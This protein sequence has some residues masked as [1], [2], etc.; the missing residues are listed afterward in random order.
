MRARRFCVLFF[1]MA[2]F[3]IAF[4]T[5]ALA[6]NETTA[7][8]DWTTCADC[9]NPGTYA[10][11]GTRFGPHGGY[12]A[13]SSACDACHTVHAAPT[14]FKLLQGATV[15]ATCMTCHDG[16][17]TIG[18]GVYGAIKGR[19]LNVSGQHRV[20]TTSV[21]P[22]GSASTGGSLTMALAGPNGTLTCS[23]CHSPHGSDCVTPYLGERQRSRAW[24]ILTLQTQN[25]LLRRHPGNVSTATAD[26]GSDW[27][28]AC[29]AGRDSGLSTV[30]NHPADSKSTTATPFTYNNVARLSAGANAT[31]TTLG[32][33]G[34]NNGG[35]LMPYPRTTQQKGHAP[36]C[37]QCHEDARN[38]GTL[39]S[40]GASGT[41]SPYVVT[42]AD[43]RTA[44]DNPRFQNFPHET[45]TYRMLVE[46]TATT[47][48]DNLCLNCHPLGQLP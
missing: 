42:A 29:H 32:S 7:T 19:G 24:G 26:Y 43:G 11:N 20:E 39:S 33:L 45:T 23:D 34:A 1:L 16:T 47:F 37:Q 10:G 22:G 4:A 36:I 41:V 12:T 40:G 8:V 13:T 48:T 46:A 35:Y 3:L 5:P 18:E 14:T 31:A 28:I 6:F 21:V 38:V 44:S 9:H 30:R 17:S 27:C 2:G 25:R 15:Y